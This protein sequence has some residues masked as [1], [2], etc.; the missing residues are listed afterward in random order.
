MDSSYAAEDVRLVDFPSNEPSPELEVGRSEVA[1]IL[2]VEISRTPPLLRKVYV[3]RDVQ[4]LPMPEVAGRLGISV[5]GRKVQTAAG[6]RGTSE[7]ASK[8][9]GRL[10]PAT[11]LA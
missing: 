4:D 8:E 10:G 5:A 2:A 9:R 7:Q 6:S 1:Q 3:L 11:L